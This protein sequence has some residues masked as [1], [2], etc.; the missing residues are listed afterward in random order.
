MTI[1]TLGILFHA[2][3]AVVAGAAFMDCAWGAFDY[4]VRKRP[5]LLLMGELAFQALR[6]V[7]AEKTAERRRALRRNK[8]FLA[9]LAWSAAVAAPLYFY[10]AA[11]A[12]VALLGFL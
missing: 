6:V 1:A 9:V 5:R 2:T 10:L 8:P 11:V 12:V 4:F 7:S 3:L